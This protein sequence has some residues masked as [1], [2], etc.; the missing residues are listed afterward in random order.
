MR[1]QDAPSG[2]ALTLGAAAGQGVAL[3]PASAAPVIA[4]AQTRKDAGSPAN[5]R[6]AGADRPF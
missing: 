1:K 2:T 6:L 5:P 3:V 4:P